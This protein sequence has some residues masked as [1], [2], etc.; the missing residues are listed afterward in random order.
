MT[1]RKTPKLGSAW[2]GAQSSNEKNWLN[3]T[4]PKNPIVG[5][6]S[7]ITIAVVVT[8]EITAQAASPA[9]ISFSPQRGLA[10]AR[11]RDGGPVPIGLAAAI[12]SRASMALA[13]SG[14]EC[15]G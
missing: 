10:A 6:S 13:P 7:E 5:E 1:M 15:P 12:V 14:S 11:D 8:T 2:G 3:E 4:S 9:W